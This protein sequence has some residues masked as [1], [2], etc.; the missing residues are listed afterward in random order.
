MTKTGLLVAGSAL[1]VLAAMPVG[2]QVAPTAEVSDDSVEQ[3]DFVIVVTAQKREQNLQDVPLAISVVGGEE[4]TEQGAASLVDYA[5]YV[6]GMQVTNSGTP[7]QGTITLRG[8]AALSGSATVGIY[9]DDAPVGSSNIYNRANAFAIDLL[10]YDIERVEVLRGPQ[11]TLYGASSIGGLLKYVTVDPSTDEFSVRGG[12]EEFGIEG[13]DGLGWAVNTLVSAPL[14]QDKLGMSASFSWRSTP[15]WVDSINNPDLDDQN[16]YEQLGGRVAMLIEPTPQLSI[17][18]SGIWQQIDSEGNGQYAADLDD[19]RVGD[20]RSFNNFLPEPYEFD[21]DY[22]AA[23]IDYDFGG[24]VLTSATT[25]SE[26]Q[27]LQATDATQIFGILFP[28]LTGGAIDAGLSPFDINLGLDK[29]TQEVRLASPGGGRFEWLLGG[30]YT[31]E[32]TSNSQVARSLTMGGDVIAPLDPLAVVQLPATYEEYAVFGNGTFHFTDQLELTAGVRWA[33]NEQTFRQISS[34][35]IIPEAD[36]PGESSEDVFTYSV[37]P[38]FNF[39]DNAMVYARV[40]SGYRPGGPNVILPDVPPTVDA[41]RLTNYEVGFKGDFARGLASLDLAVFYM[42]WSDI[43]VTRTFGGVNGQANGGK[44]ESKGVEGTLILRPAAGLSLTAVGS[45]TDA[46]LSEDVPEISGV[47][48]DR[49]PNVPE[50]SGAVRADYEFVLGPEAMG[51]VGVGV[52]HSGSRFS[53][54]ESDP[55]SAESEP[56]T[57]VDLN[58]QMTF[59]ENWTVRAYARN[60]FDDEGELSRSTATDGLNQPIY[61]SITPVQPRTLGVALEF[62]F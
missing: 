44:A 13:G 57:T 24:A 40:A 59:G 33:K 51:A 52:R 41:D 46:T 3:D 16:D 28:L 8:I 15:G 22:Y 42:D 18:L 21:M 5:S 38:Q 19:N 54:V 14:I 27:S 37:S 55:L 25:Y 26:T 7:G 45:Y 32:E 10:P 50:F 62:N 17:S 6:P 49:L 47:D 12:V 2:A 1:A 30:F 39:S 29:F 43:Q 61:Y 60:L 36:D 53:L 9:L 20:G 56:F 34:G 4:L 23:T 31:D 11:G 58:A 35:A 48:G